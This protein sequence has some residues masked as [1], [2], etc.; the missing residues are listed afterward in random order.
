MTSSEP[1]DEAL[2]ETAAGAVQG[3]GRQDAT[4]GPEPTAP[5]GERGA[6]EFDAGDFVVDQEADPPD[7]VQPTTS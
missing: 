3:G 1:S 4:D 7:E 6:D 5:D 2:A